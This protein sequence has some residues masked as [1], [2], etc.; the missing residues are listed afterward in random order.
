[1]GKDVVIHAVPAVAFVRAAAENIQHGCP[2]CKQVFDWEGF[3]AHTAACI[4]AHPERVAEIEG[5]K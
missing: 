4:A 1:M 5:D 2:L 3:Q